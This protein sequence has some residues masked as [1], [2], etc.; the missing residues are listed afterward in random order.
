MNLLPS[1]EQF[2]RVI[3]GPPPYNMAG[4]M[5]IGVQL[6]TVALFLDATPCKRIE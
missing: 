4:K 6:D 1:T 5:L 2:F 3:A